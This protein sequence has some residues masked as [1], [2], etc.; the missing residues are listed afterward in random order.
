[1]LLDQTVYR[2]GR[3]VAELGIHIFSWFVH[4]LFCNSLPYALDVYVRSKASQDIR[5]QFIPC[6]PAL[7]LQAFFFDRGFFTAYAIGRFAEPVLAN[8]IRYQLAGRC[9]REFVLGVADRPQ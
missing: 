7:L 6:R 3:T 4:V 5:S 1:M 2:S 8:G 9:F